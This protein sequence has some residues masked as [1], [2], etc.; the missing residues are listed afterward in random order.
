MFTKPDDPEQIRD[1]LMGAINTVYEGLLFGTYK[2]QEYFDGDSNGLNFP[3]AANIARYHAKE[4]I[5][6]V[7]PSEA[8]YRLAELP[9][10]SIEIRQDWCLIKV[11]KGRNGEPPTATHTVR[12]QEFYH[13]QP[14]QQT[15]P[16]INWLRIWKTRDW[17]YFL[18]QC[19]QLN[20][21][22][23]WEVDYS[24][25]VEKVQLMCP[26]LSGK[27]WQGVRTFWRLTIPH[28][29]LGITGLQTVD[30]SQEVDDLPVYF[31]SE[32]AEQG[33]DD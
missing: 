26:R 28:P 2:A 11:L 25:G 32:T 30:E 33:N 5:K 1:F 31:E 9:N 15:L 13:Q 20:L 21:I 14:I 3:L 27:Y 12:S 29:V 17:K 22:L 16:G 24:Y 8:P 19:T 7:R 4:Y 10:N 6:R 18:E 23:C